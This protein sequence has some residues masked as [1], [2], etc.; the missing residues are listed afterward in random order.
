MAGQPK[1]YKTVEELQEKIDAYFTKQD[2]KYSDRLVPVYGVVGL[3]SFLG[4]DRETL[5]NYGKD[6]EYFGTIKAAKVKIESISEERLIAGEGNVTGVIFNLKNNYGWKDASQ[7]E[8]TGK[9]GKDFTG[10]KVEFVSKDK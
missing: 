6:E 2:I 3:A 5:L 1:K 7:Q 8:I 4:V 10:L 9:D